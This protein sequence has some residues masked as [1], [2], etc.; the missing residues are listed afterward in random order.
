MQE[1][2][3]PSQVHEEESYQAGFSDSDGKRCDGV[4]AAEIDE[5]QRGRQAGQNNQ[6]H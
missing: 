4:E 2:A 6:R 1:A 5:G 3:A